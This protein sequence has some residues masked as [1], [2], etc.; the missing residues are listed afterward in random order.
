V[1]FLERTCMYSA[2]IYLKSRTLRQLTYLLCVL[3]EVIPSCGICN[4]LLLRDLE[5]EGS[6]WRAM[7]K[8]SAVETAGNL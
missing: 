3:I 2:L 4:I 1:G 7:L 8:P 5:L 6:I